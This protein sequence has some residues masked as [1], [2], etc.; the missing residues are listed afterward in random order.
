MNLNTNFKIPNYEKLNF[1]LNTKWSD[2]ARDYGN[3][4]SGSYDDVRLD[5]YIVCDL[6]IK[7]NLLN[8]YNLLISLIYSMRDMQTAKDYQQMS[9]SFNFGLKRNF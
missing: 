7:Y 8:E 9:R 2:E 3:G 5:D 6:F 4:N 1:T